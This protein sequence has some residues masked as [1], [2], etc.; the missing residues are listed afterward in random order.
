MTDYQLRLAQPEDADRLYVIHKLAMRDLVEQVY[1][2]WDDQ[3]QRRMHSEWLS[4]S[5]VQ[6]IEH[7]G[8][9]VGALHVR[10][11][12]DHAYLGRIE[13]E[14]GHQ[15]RGLGTTLTTD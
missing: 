3:A 11:E 4:S 6:V 2:L 14:P 10:W 8:A 5:A 9:I 1:G 7:E 15:G 13:L 12:S